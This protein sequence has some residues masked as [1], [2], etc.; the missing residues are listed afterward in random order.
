MVHNWVI[1]PC[2]PTYFVGLSHALGRESL[3]SNYAVFTL[4]QQFRRID[5]IITRY[6]WRESTKTISLYSDLVFQPST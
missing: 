2:F 3:H 5:Y 4:S 1:S 6:L